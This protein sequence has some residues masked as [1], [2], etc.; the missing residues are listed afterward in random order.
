MFIKS[1]IVRARSSVWRKALFMKQCR[2]LSGM[3]PEMVAIVTTIKIIGKQN[4]QNHTFT[5]SVKASGVTRGL[6]LGGG[7]SSRGLQ[8]DLIQVKTKKRLHQKFGIF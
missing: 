8:F 1:L 7:G 5:Y 6:C 2:Y 3:A 4:T